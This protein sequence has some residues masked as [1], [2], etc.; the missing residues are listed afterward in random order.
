MNLKCTC[1]SESFKA[2]TI[3][4]TLHEVPCTIDASDGPKYDG[5]KAEYYEGWDWAAPE[6][7]AIKCLDCG[8]VYY[9]AHGTQ[10][11]IIL[12]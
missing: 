1:G 5:T 2:E 12:L 6:Q 4:I 3:K 7:D 8:H 9:L 11:T 10:G